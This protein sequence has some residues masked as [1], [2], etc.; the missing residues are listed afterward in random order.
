MERRDGIKGFAGQAGSVFRNG[1]YEQVTASLNQAGIDFA[2]LPGVKPNPVLSKVKAGIELAREYKAEAVLAAG[3]G[4]VFDSAKIIAAGYH[5]PGDVWDFFTGAAR[6]KQALPIYGVLTI[7]GTGSEMNCNAVL[8]RED[9][10]KKWGLGS[11]HLYPRLSIIDPSVQGTLPAQN[12][13]EG[14]ADMITHILGI[15]STAVPILTS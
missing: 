14:A 2:E 12:T 10:R 8:T 13:A 3:G 5:Y 11:R 7:S 6:I 15:A 9:E 4:S 1:V